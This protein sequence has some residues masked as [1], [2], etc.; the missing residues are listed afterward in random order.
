[1]RI[2][3]Y[4]EYLED[5]GFT[6][7]AHANTSWRKKSMSAAKR[8]SFGYE[9]VEPIKIL[10]YHGDNSGNVNDVYEALVNN[11]DCPSYVS[12]SESDVAQASNSEFRANLADI[13]R[14]KRADWKLIEVEICWSYIFLNYWN[15]KYNTKEY[16]GISINNR[17]TFSLQLAPTVFD[18]TPIYNIDAVN[19]GSES[20]ARCYTHI[21]EDL[22]YVWRH[23]R[24]A[25]HNSDIIT[26]R[27]EERCGF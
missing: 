17:I 6:I 19:Y 1:M 25:K 27:V 11:I 16:V 7:S 23:V 4:K 26:L 10:P 20:D 2:R 5:E 12:E 21:Y 22:G 18:F 8:T 3:K 24:F 13:I 14:G 9:D 15:P